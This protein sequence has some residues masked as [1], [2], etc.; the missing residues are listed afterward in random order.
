MNSYDLVDVYRTLHKDTRKYSWRRFKSTQRSRLD[1]LL[2]SEVLGLD[3]TSADIVM[4]FAI[5]SKSGTSDKDAAGGMHALGHSS[6]GHAQQ[7]RPVRSKRGQGGV[8]NG[9]SRRGQQQSGAS[10]GACKCYRCGQNHHASTCKFKKYECHGCHKKGHLKSMCRS[11]VRFLDA[12]TSGDEDYEEETLGIFHT[13]TPV[14]VSK[15]QR[16]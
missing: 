9:G 5:V 12:Q 16:W 3:I 4:F 13:S 11:K 7:P 8:R 2:V 10:T 1:Y 6:N 14:K 15:E